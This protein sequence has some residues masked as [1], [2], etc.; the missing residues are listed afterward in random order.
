MILG[1]RFL[2]ASVKVPYKIRLVCIIVLLK[3]GCMRNPF[4]AMILVH[5][6]SVFITARLSSH[7]SGQETSPPRIE[8]IVTVIALGEVPN[9]LNNDLQRLSSRS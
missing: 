4:A 9:T 6:V 8:I 5:F 7:D 3:T 2:N 1:S